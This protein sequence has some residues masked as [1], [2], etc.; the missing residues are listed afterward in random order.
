MYY[1]EGSR[2][3]T[4]TVSNINGKPESATSMTLRPSFNISATV[5]IMEETFVAAASIWKNRLEISA[6]YTGE[7][8]FKF[9]VLAKTANTLGPQVAIAA[10]GKTKL[11]EAIIPTRKQFEFLSGIRILKQDGFRLS[12]KS[13][14]EGACEGTASYDKAIPI[15]DT[16]IDG[17]N[18]SALGTRREFSPSKESE[19]IRNSTLISRVPCV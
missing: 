14:T 10:L 12:L 17:P 7:L 13:E 9:C 18:R 1:L 4:F 16:Q 5:G 8:D 15:G 11:N 19:S 3:E 2:N 6:K